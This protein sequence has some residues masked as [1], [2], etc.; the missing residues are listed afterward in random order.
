MAA[1]SKLT[2]TAPTTIPLDKLVQSDANV[3]RVNAAISIEALAE[4]IARRGLLQSLSVRPL[5]DDEGSESDTYE[6]QAGGRRLRALKLLVKRKQLAKNAPIACIVKT[7]GILEDDSLAENTD[8][9]ALH[10]LDQFRAFAALRAKGQSEEDIAAAFGVT[11]AIVR[12]RLKLASASPKLLDA[13]AA[14]E[15]DLDQLMAFCVTDNHDRQEQV[16]DAIAQGQVGGH[17][18]TIRRLL[19]ETCVEASDPRARFVGVEAYSAAGGTIMRDLFDE[20][21]GG[22][23]QDPD[24]LMR[25][26]SEKLA[27]ERERLL[28]Q[29][30]KW[31]EAA[32]ELSYELTFQLRRLQPID[33][34]LSEAEQAH[35]DAL[36]AEHDGLIEDLSD[37]DIPDEVRARLDAIEAELAELDNRAPEFAAGGHGARRRSR[38]H[39]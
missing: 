17:A 2:L 28:A 7:T 10:P 4:S 33:A 30:W 22:W 8:R 24:L 15:L 39:Q 32:V 1:K 14:D 21:D 13:Y 3:R 37:D 23:L 12:Q 25:L 29:G 5:L 9:E 6:V 31:V 34:A 36:A 16:F 27:A 26:V 18:F 19:T 38:Q 35:Y 11:P 20:D